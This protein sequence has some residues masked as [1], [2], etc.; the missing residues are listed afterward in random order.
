[1]P[2]LSTT[3]EPLQLVEVTPETLYEYWPFIRRGLDV[4]HSKLK[5]D[6]FPEE[7][8][9]AFRTGT[10]KFLV[11]RRG[12]RLL[13]FAGYY[14]ELRLFTLK[15]R[16]FVWALWFLPLRERQPTDNF[17]EVFWTGLRYLSEVATRQ[18]GTHVIAWIT[19]DKRRRGYERKYG[20]KPTC[21][22]FEIEV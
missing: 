9:A 19:T 15:P 16:L 8:F 7:Q 10:H 20:F 12:N 2:S 22:T 17:H 14:R 13:G 6:W 3:S 1:M 5:T 4:I 11:A 18:Y 21:S